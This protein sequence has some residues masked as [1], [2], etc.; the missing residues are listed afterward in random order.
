VISKPH[1]VREYSWRTAP[2]EADKG[3]SARMFGG[4]RFFVGLRLALER[5]P[6][7]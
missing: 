5:D 2:P 1:L 7:F 6:A 4:L 3:S